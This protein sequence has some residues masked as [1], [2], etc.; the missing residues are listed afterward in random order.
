[1]VMMQE[2]LIALVYRSKSYLSTHYDTVRLVEVFVKHLVEQ[3]DVEVATVHVYFVHNTLT[4]NHEGVP[5]LRFIKNNPSLDWL[6][7][8]PQTDT[9]YHCTVTLKKLAI[10][11]FCQKVQCR[12]ALV[13]FQY[14]N[15]LL[16]F[17]FHKKKLAFPQL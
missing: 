1:M 8:A 3:S 13:R 7:Y 17:S 15:Q 14:N 5:T 2:F 6:L 12:T 11:L 4:F 16:F 10:Y 9:Q